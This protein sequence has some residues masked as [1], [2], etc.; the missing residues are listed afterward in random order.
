MI[1]TFFFSA[2]IG[3][4]GLFAGAAGAFLGFVVAGKGPQ[5]VAELA[6]LFRSFV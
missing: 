2:G 1:K 4:G 3:F 6:E 5:L